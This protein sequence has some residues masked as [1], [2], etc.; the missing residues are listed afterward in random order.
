MIPP[1][2]DTLPAAPALPATTRGRVEDVVAQTA[3]AACCPV[4]THGVNES[5]F[6]TRFLCLY[7]AARRGRPFFPSAPSLV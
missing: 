7:R 5:R 1:P 6:V 3:H 2:D 4:L